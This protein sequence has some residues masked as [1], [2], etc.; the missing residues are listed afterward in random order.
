MDSNDIN[1][2]ASSTYDTL[3]RSPG[4]VRNM[5]RCRAFIESNAPCRHPGVMLSEQGFP[6]HGRVWIKKLVHRIDN[7]TYS[8]IEH[9]IDIEN[10]RKYHRMRLIRKEQ[11][12]RRIKVGTWNVGS[13]TGKL[14]ELVDTLERKRVNIACIQETKW[15]GEKSKE[16]GN[17]GYKLWFTGK[18]RN[19]NGVGII[20][21]RT[22][23][24]AIITVKRVGDRIILVK[25]V[26]EGKTINVVSAY[27]PQ[28]GLDSESKQMFWEDMDDLMQ[29]I[30]NEENI[31]IG[32]DL[33]GHVGSDRQGYE[34]VHKGFGF[35]SQNKEGKNILDF[36]MAY[37]LILANTYFI[38]RELHLVTFKS[39]QHRS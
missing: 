4:V 9:K 25:L 8:G 21:D 15:I 7:R 11:D 36:A 33:N 37:D 38:K 31:F 12:R 20:I 3:H 35:C 18:E 34:N 13:L 26:L 24:N 6:H 2:G 32:G 1:V 29:S 28:I 39:G 19:K 22:L 16:V 30:P 23:K 27:A 17:S 5:Q 10:N 14:M